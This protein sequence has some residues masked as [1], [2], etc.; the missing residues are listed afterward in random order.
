M[1]DYIASKPKED[2]EEED[3]NDDK[4]TVNSKGVI[5]NVER[6]DA[7]NRFF[8]EDGNEL[9]FHDPEGVDKPYVNT[10]YSIEERLFYSISIRNEQ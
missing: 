5:T 1:K 2:E 3:K 7:A 9:F 4:I 8:D 10:R 6:D